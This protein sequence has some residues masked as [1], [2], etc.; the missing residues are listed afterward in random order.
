[1]VEAK[2]S[3]ISQDDAQY[4]LSDGK[5]PGGVFYRVLCAKYSCPDIPMSI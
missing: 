1:M 4:Y 3:R 2:L 5:T